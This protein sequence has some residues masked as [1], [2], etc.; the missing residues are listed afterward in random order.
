M[1]ANLSDNIAPILDDEGDNVNR[2]QDDNDDDDGDD[3]DGR[4]IPEA[5]EVNERGST[6]AAAKGEDGKDPAAEEPK[7]KRIVRN[8]Q[9]KLDPNRICGPRGVGTLETVFRD[10][11]SHGKGREFDDL[12][13]V[14]KRMEHWAHRLYPKLPFDDVM[15]RIAQLGKKQAVKTYV[16]KIRLNMVGPVGGGAAGGGDGEDEEDGAVRYEDGEGKEGGGEE[17]DVF[18]KLV[19]EA[20]EEEERRRREQQQD[21]DEEMVIRDTQTIPSS[22]QANTTTTSLSEEARERMDRNR[23]MAEKKRRERA[24]RAAEQR[25]ATKETVAGN[26]GTEEKIEEEVG[27]QVVEKSVERAAEMETEERQ[28]N[29]EQ[30][31]EASHQGKENEDAQAPME[32]DGSAA[33]QQT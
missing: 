28:G 12:E 15:E 1:V 24:A 17:E 3:D 30:Q 8:P 26:S 13:A 16:R 18:A 33:V 11:K 19:R 22:S 23:R 2:Y 20:D 4:N 10:F 29:E 7:K 6:A 21:E 31:M 5:V 25:M 14:M 27:Q 9:P 32:D